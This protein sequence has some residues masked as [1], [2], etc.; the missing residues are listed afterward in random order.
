MRLMLI[1][2]TLVVLVVIDQYRFNGF[3]GAE[4][5]RIAWLALGGV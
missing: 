3:Y 2:L 4:L 5:S 1:A